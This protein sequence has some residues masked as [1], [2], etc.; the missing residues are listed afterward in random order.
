MPD[1]FEALKGGRLKIREGGFLALLG[2]NGPQQTTPDFKTV[3]WELQTGTGGSVYVGGFD[4]SPKPWRTLDD[5]AGP[6]EINLEPSRKV[7]S[8]V[9]FSRGCFASQR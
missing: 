7:I 6:A 9:R 5:R 3:L 1:G 4:R 8:T 2:P